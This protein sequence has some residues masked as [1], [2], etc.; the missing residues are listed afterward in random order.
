MYVSKHV[1]MFETVNYLAVA[2]SDSSR[3][4]FI[5]ERFIEFSKIFEGGLLEAPDIHTC[6]SKI[7]HKC[8]QQSTNKHVCMFENHVFY[9]GNETYIHAQ[10]CLKSKK[11]HPEAPP[12]RVCMFQNLCILS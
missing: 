10:S 5:I 4:T 8:Y 2:G 12:K 3:K 9:H 11:N 6:L 7:S 1:Y